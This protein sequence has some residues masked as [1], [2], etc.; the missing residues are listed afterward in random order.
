MFW[1]ITVNLNTMV[2]LKNISEFKYV[3]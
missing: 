2:L 3:G 1:Q